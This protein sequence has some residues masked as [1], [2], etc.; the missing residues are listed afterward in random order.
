ML[1]ATLKDS[2][3]KIVT[4]T[5]YTISLLSQATGPQFDKSAKIVIPVILTTLA[6]NKKPV[7][8]E[9]LK[10]MDIL[11]NDITLEPFVSFLPVA[12][13]ADSSTGRKEVLIVHTYNMINSRTGIAMGDKISSQL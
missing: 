12:M 6:D 13:A 1:K 2:N 8:D 5:L 9:G 4:T 11:V 7:R 10:T 3:Q